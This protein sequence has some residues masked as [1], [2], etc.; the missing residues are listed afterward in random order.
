MDAL[1]EHTKATVTNGDVMP[2]DDLPE[3]C[4]K[5]LRQT[6]DSRKGGFGEAPKFPQPG[7][8]LTF[9]HQNDI[10]YVHTDVCN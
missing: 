8:I 9:Y 3:K 6:Y 1:K 4:Y 10:S 7:S 2:T 5:V